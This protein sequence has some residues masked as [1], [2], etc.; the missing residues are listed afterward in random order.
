[1]RF[2]SPITENK[3]CDNNWLEKLCIIDVGD[4]KS[5]EVS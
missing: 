5:D 1:M 2:K 3:I 4:I